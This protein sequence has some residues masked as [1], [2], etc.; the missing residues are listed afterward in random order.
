MQPGIQAY[1]K[2]QTLTLSQREL[3]ARAL[4]KAAAKLQ[5]IKENWV[6]SVLHIED[7]ISHNRKVWTIFLSSAS[8][9]DCPLPPD[10]RK[11][12]IGLSR[13]VVNQCMQMLFQPDH[14]KLDLLIEIN[15]NVAAGL[16]GQQLPP[17]VAQALPKAS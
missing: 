13:F 2:T 5:A 11:N 8:E 6:P 17:E 3:E 10:V 1:A 12:I 4:M 14:A 15:Q 7:A 16:Q 9:D